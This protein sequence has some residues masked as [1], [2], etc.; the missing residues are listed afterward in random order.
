M[1]RLAGR[2]G[3]LERATR[4]IGDGAMEE[5]RW[6]WDPVARAYRQGDTLKDVAEMIQHV[7]AEW[8]RGVAVVCAGIYQREVNSESIE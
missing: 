3:R 5:D 1:G 2:V 4:P 6:Y 8:R 7:A